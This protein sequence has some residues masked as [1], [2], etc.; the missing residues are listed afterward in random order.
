MLKRILTTT[1][2]ISPS[3]LLFSQSE[4]KELDI[5]QFKF[6]PDHYST[7]SL[8][9]GL[10]PIL[11]S[12]GSFTI[13]G[14]KNNY[15]FDNQANYRGETARE[16]AA[17]VDSS[18]K[19][20]ATDI[21]VFIRKGNVIASIG[22]YQL[23]YS[24]SGEVHTANLEK[25]ISYNHKGEEYEKVGSD[26]RQI[27]SVT[28]EEIIFYQHYFKMSEQTHP[29]IKP[30]R[31]VPYSFMRI[32]RCNLKTGSVTFEYLF[33]DQFEKHKD[34]SAGEHPVKKVHFI[35]LRNN[36][37]I[38]GFTNYTTTDYSI[39][40]GS[41]E[42][43]VKVPIEII[44]YYSISAVDLKSS[45]EN[46]LA[47]EQIKKPSE[48]F[49]LAFFPTNYGFSLSWSKKYDRTIF[50]SHADL[51][52]VGEDLSISNTSILF[53]VEDL[54]MKSG[55]PVYLQKVKILDGSEWFALNARFSN[56]KR[57]QD[58]KDQAPVIIL[59]NKDGEIQYRDNST[60][61]WFVGY[62]KLDEAKENEECLPCLIDLDKDAF[63]FM[64]EIPN[65]SE[66]TELAKK[67]S[68]GKS[69]S[70]FFVRNG[71][72]INYV[73]VFIAYK[74]NLRTGAEERIKIYIRTG[75]VSLD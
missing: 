61:K 22:H 43:T 57:R 6:K 42:E 32:G 25:V 60:L 50:E 3:F 39:R 20:V 68:Y 69:N 4:W 5:D 71:N 41:A 48:A 72:L 10:H 75:S 65:D 1:L 59:I 54:P 14:L 47:V 9:D 51:I 70:T 64:E 26:S 53:P 30:V 36:Q 52:E 16:I 29:G 7:V 58:I 37:A 56:S 67:F 40:T 24:I 31:G 38:F 46:E 44:G 17:F 63:K 8:D 19:V 73:Q 35:G 62:D 27:I 74:S 18:I 28:D 2:F 23:F 66:L 21:P 12:D 49:A 11:N 15:L 33:V 55:V 34:F 45:N 13:P